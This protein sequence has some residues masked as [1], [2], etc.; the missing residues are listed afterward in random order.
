MNLN[1]PFYIDFTPKQGYY[2]V[3]QWD[4][5][6]KQG[7]YIPDQGDYILD[8]G[9]N[10]LDQGDYIPKQGDYIIVKETELPCKG[11]ISKFNKATAV[12]AITFLFYSSCNGHESNQCFLP[13]LL[14]PCFPLCFFLFSSL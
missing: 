14:L 12:C 9:Y 8:Q 13:L 7:D 4:Y 10:I 6:P 3:V 1:Y 5:I 11:S 2:N